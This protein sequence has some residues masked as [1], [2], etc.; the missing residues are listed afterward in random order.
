LKKGEAA[1]P[2][3]IPLSLRKLHFPLKVNEMVDIFNRLPEHEIIDCILTAKLVN[4]NEILET[5]TCR[6][7]KAFRVR[8]ERFRKY[9]QNSALF[10]EKILLSLSII[11]SFSLIVSTAS[12]LL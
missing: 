12:F 5:V 2:E 7:S 9:L 4:N 1:K 6:T 3:K 8:I 11:Q 10:E